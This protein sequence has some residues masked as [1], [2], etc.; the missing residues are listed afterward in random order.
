MLKFVILSSN[1]ENI[2]GYE[3]IVDKLLM[4]HEIEYKCYKFND[5]D[6]EFNNFIEQEQ[7]DNIYIIEEGNN[8]NSLELIKQ[9]RNNHNDRLENGSGRINAQ[10]LPSR[11]IANDQFFY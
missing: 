7:E 8:I 3:T 2:R 11:H 6:K 5:N 1:K 9:I 10:H 4:R